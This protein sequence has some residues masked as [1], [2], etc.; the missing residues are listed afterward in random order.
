MERNLGLCEGCES[1]E[2]LATDSRNGEFNRKCFMVLLEWY[3]ANRRNFEKRKDIYEKHCEEE[4]Q[5][6]YKVAFELVEWAKNMVLYDASKM[7]RSAIK[8]KSDIAMEADEEERIYTVIRKIEGKAIE[9]E[10]RCAERGCSVLY[11]LLRRLDVYYKVNEWLREELCKQF[12]K[13]FS[14]QDSGF[15]NMLNNRLYAP[16][17]EELL[18]KCINKLLAKKV[19]NSR[20]KEVPLFSK[21]AHWKAVWEVLHER[22]FAIAEQFE[23]FARFIADN[24]KIIYADK[25]YRIEDSS[26]IRNAEETP[27]KERVRKEFEKYLDEEGL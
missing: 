14:N 17:T 24:D 6:V 12:E 25:D 11:Q 4:I 18:T 9:F 16:D 15:F 10:K 27:Q 21:K 2:E 22:Y 8:A 3:K 7:S 26:N 19:V 20:R 13:H 5:E 1:W 23:G